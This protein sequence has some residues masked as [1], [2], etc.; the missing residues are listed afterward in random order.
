MMEGVNSA[1]MY[2]KNFS[3]NVT[4]YPQHNN[5]KNK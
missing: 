3:I 2:C 5:N 4:M 1:M